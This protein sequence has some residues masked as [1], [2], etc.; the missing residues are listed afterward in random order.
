LRQQS[1]CQF[2][3]PRLGTRRGLPLDLT[4][5]PVAASREG[6]DKPRRSSRIIQRLAQA[7][8]GVVQ[9][10]VEIYKGVRRP[11]SL[12]QFLARNY[13]S[14]TL[15]HHGQDLKRLLLKLDS[16]PVFPKLACL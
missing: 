11:K 1:R 8:D 14:G 12:P 4:Y 7:I 13:S 2:A 6:L 15:Q 16:D 9:T 5:K 3:R 10:V